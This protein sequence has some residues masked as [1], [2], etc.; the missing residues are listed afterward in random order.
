MAERLERA[1][2][3]EQTAGEM[4]GGRSVV[5]SH[6]RQSINLR[7]DIASRPAIIGRSQL[8][9]VNTSHLTLSLRHTTHHGSSDLL[10]GLSAHLHL[11]L[12]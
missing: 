8:H 2:L 7:N 12:S 11:T 3:A 1:I 10:S 4:Y 6:Q 5:G 9:L